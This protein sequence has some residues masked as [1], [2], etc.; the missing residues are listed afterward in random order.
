[1]PED[2]TRFMAP[3]SATPLPPAVSRLVLAAQED[4]KQQLA[5]QAEVHAAK[6]QITKR[7]P[8]S[9]SKLFT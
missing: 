6:A 4:L 9:R 5:K 8:L 3:L 7:W 1:M 2:E